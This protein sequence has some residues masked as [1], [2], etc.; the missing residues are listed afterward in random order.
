MFFVLFCGQLSPPHSRC[1][2]KPRCFPDF[3]ILK[4]CVC[5]DRPHGRLIRQQVLF[6]RSV[7]IAVKPVQLFP[8]HLVAT[9]TLGIIAVFSQSPLTGFTPR[10][11]LL[12]LL[13]AAIPTVVGHN[14]YNYLLKYIKAHLVAVTILG[15]PIGAT[16]LAALILSEYPALATYIGGLL[17]LAGIFLALARTKSDIV[18]SKTA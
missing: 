8:V 17:I 16:I 1:Q 14:L 12:F 7:H 11:W 4:A 2:V 5:K 18:T 6:H 13:L 9:I 3:H 15:E 10:V